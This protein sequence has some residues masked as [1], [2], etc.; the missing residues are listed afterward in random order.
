MYCG[1]DVSKNKSN[2]CLL[3]SSM[4]VEEEFE[5][6]HTKEGFQK[7]K[8]KIPKGTKVGLEVTANYCKTLYPF[9]K[10]EGYEAIYVDNVQ[11]NIFSKLYSP[12]IKND[13][14]DARL[15]A[16]Y[17]STDF[18]HLN[19]MQMTELKDLSRVY[20]KITKQ[21]TRYK[22]MFKDQIGIVFPEL[23]KINQ[24]TE[25]RAILYL[26]SKYPT[27]QKILETDPAKIQE[28]LNEKLD[29]KFYNPDRTQKI[30]NLAKESIGVKDY[31]TKCLQQIADL[32]QKYLEI[33][34]NIKKEMKL[35]IQDTPYTPLLDEYGF[36]TI[37]VATI[38]G[39]IGDIRR[40]PTHK[41]F[42]SYCGLDI[43]EHT[44]GSSINKKSRITKQ[45]NVILRK[46]FYNLVLCQLRYKTE[47]SEF[48]YRLGKAGKH[49]QQCAVALSRKLAIKTYY[50]MKRCHN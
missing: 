34:N 33:V 46:I 38:I 4:K 3:N 23:E 40:F 30:I 50:N 15:I 25:S 36:R 7:I 26:I 11:M 44:S 45:G 13:K 5:I 2:I 17:V 18:K 6:T 21:L 14:A 9:L 49:P 41:H 8:E 22:L 16:R 47:L 43:S 42:V 39:E 28:T 20:Y 12:K 35:S 48:Y 19:I 31:P 27:P 24:L 29:Y 32:T 10:N 37:S 1:I